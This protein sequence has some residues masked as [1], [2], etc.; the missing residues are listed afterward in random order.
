M[1]ECIGR[2]QGDRRRCGG[3]DAV[4]V[5]KGGRAAE[6]APPLSHCAL[7][8]LQRELVGAE[9]RPPCVPLLVGAREAVPFRV[10]FGES[11]RSKE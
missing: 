10:L 11:P 3:G 1:S 4:D 5:D 6:N 7:F 9:G 8:A 2:E